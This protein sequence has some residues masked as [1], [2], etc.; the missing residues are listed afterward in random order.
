MHSMATSS[1][2]MASSK[3]SMLAR[4]V[5]NDDQRK[6][7]TRTA[8]IHQ[9]L[10][11]AKPSVWP[12]DRQR[13][14]VA[15]LR[16]RFTFLGLSIVSDKTYALEQKTRTYIDDRTYPT[17]FPLSSS[18]RKDKSGQL[19]IICCPGRQLKRWPAAYTSG[20]A[21]NTSCSSSL[22]CYGGCM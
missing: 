3:I 20:E 14:D 7:G 15:D 9:P 5:Y 13:I 8:Q 1:R 19:N 10:G 16:I 2:N 18:A 22:G 17:T 6:E 4:N 11:E 21:H 12:E